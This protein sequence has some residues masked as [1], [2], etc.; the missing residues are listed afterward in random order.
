MHCDKHVVKM[1]IEYAQLLSTAHRILDGQEY[2]DKTTNG[3]SIRRWRM[4]DDVENVLMKASHINHPSAVWAR[5]SAD[6]YLWLYHLWFDLCQEYTYRYEKVHSCYNRLKAVLYKVPKN[7]LLKEFTQPPPAMPDD[8]KIL[9]D[10]LGSYRK[11]YVER[12][13]HFAKWKCREVPVWYAEGLNK[14]NA[15]V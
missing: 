13:N 10:S 14:N 5:Q 7:I 2:V 9:G 4:S 6:N 1:I 3:R 11:Y 8:C 12:K 15:H